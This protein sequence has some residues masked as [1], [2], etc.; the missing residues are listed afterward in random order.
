MV[1]TQ[2]IVCFFKMVKYGANTTHL[3]VHSSM[4]SDKGSTTH[5]HG[6]RVTVKNQ[7]SPFMTEANTVPGYS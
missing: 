6:D 7:R 5:V 2:L 3:A 1:K 4:C